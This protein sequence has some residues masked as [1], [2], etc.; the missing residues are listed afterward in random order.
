MPEKGH[1]REE[2]VRVFL[3]PDKAGRASWTLG[4]SE[5]DPIGR[6]KTQ[7]INET[8]RKLNNMPLYRHMPCMQ[9]SKNLKDAVC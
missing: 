3:M 1:L 5:T 4:K 8:E 7:S 2:L 6:K 9:S